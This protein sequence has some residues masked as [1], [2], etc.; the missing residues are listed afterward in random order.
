MKI[1][2]KYRTWEMSEKTLFKINIRYYPTVEIEWKTRNNF[3]EY[4]LNLSYKNKWKQVYLKSL[5]R[6]DIF[7]AI[8]RAILEFRRELKKDKKIIKANIMI[9]DIT[10]RM[11]EEMKNYNNFL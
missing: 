9:P 1:I 5:K 2:E 3:D 10:H 7:K 8:I 6:W 11:Q 4:Q